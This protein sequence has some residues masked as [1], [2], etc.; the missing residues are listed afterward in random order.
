MEFRNKRSVWTVSPENL[1]Y[2]HFA[3]FP[4]KLVEPCI[5]AGCPEGGIVYDPFMGSGTVAIV[6]RKNR[7]NYVGAEISPGSI[8]IAHERLYKELGMFQDEEF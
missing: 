7:R 4:Q 1:K 2:A 8:G 5:K 6:A 3:T